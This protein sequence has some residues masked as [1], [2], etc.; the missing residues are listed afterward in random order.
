VHNIYAKGSVIKRLVL[1][2]EHKLLMADCRTSRSKM[3]SPHLL[4]LNFRQQKHISH[5]R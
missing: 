1:L 2:R 3:I 4:N 5:N